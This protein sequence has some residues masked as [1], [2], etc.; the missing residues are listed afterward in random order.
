MR[1]LLV[2]LLALAPAP[3]P[4]A[5]GE[6]AGKVFLT[7]EEALKLAFPE[8][9]IERRT[10]YLSEAE[11]LRIESLARVELA[12]RV[13]R[14]YVARKHGELVGTAY[15]DAHRVRTKNEVLLLVIGP[16]ERLKRVEV[17]SFAEPLEYLPRANFYAQFSGQ[18]LDDELDLKHAIRGVAGASLSANAAAA[19]ARR[20]LAV[21]H[22]LAERA[23]AVPGASA[24]VR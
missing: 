15:F 22:V 4:A 6:G 21:Q 20:A 14:P 19:A 5:L 12:G 24:A 17:L 1:A 23:T 3:T 2:L 9:E 8:C 10:E 16:D 18:R 13:V 7:P 11:E